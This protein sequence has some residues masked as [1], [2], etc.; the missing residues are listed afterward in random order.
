M[1]S[2]G[3]ASHEMRLVSGMFPDVEAA[4]CPCC[5]A[6]LVPGKT[7]VDLS[8]NTIVGPRG[9]LTVTGKEAVLLDV[10][11]RAK[12]RVVDHDRII[13]VLWPRGE[14]DGAYATMK[15]HIWHVRRGQGHRGRQPLSSIGLAIETV[16]DRGYRIVEVPA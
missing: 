8:T 10:L 16:R 4:R 5:G 12:G 7:M 6:P 14:P 11:L 13:S 3:G 2:A 15:A 9:A 1:S